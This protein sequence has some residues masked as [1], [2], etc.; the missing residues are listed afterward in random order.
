MNFSESKT[1]SKCKV[2]MSLSTIGILVSEEPAYRWR[3]SDRKIMAES[4]KRNSIHHK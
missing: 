4:S 2:D 3:P 1:Y